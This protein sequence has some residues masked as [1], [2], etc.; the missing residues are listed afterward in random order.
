MKPLNL[1]QMHRNGLAK[2]YTGCL[3]KHVDLLLKR[4]NSVIYGGNVKRV[5]I[6]FGCSKL[7]P[8]GIND[9]LLSGGAAYRNCRHN[10]VILCLTSFPVFCTVETAS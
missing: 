4:C 10:V 2:R 8:L 1:S 6:F 3:K 5:Q 9:V 7:I